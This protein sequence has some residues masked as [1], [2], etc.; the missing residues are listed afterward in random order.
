MLDACDRLGM[1]VMDEMFDIWTEA[2]SAVRLLAG[3]PGVVGARRRGDGREG[4]QPPERDPVLDRQRD[5]RDRHARSAPSW[6]R[7]LAEKVRSLDD[8]RFV[9]NAI[10][11]LVA[12]ARSDAAS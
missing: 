6:G 7:K 1:L 8:T 4:L 12:V 11:H 5:L 2:K 9:T 10:N 3:L